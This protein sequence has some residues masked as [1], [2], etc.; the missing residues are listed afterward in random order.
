MWLLPPAPLN[1]CGGSLAAF[2]LHKGGP[3]SWGPMVRGSHGQVQG[4]T[5]SR[6]GTVQFSYQIWMSSWKCEWS[7]TIPLL[8]LAA[9]PIFPQ[10]SSGL[11]LLQVSGAHYLGRDSR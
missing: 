9:S 6:T 1:S 3:P 10:G 5:E 7:R 2:L 4:Q 11:F 8:G